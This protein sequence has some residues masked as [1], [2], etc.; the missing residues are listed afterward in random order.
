VRKASVVLVDRTRVEPGDRL[1]PIVGACLKAWALQDPEVA[2]AARIDVVQ[3]ADGESDE[4][5]VRRIVAGAPALVGFSCYVWNVAAVRGLAARVKR[6]L[7]DARIVLGGPEVGPIPERALAS[8]PAAD[9][10]CLGEGEETFRLLV[11]H[12]LLGAGAPAGVPGL[13]YR[14]ADGAVAS[15]G[16]APLIELGRA[17]SPHLDG[18]ARVPAG[19]DAMI[20]LSRGCAFECKFCDWPSL[21]L[22]RYVPMERVRRELAHLVAAGAGRVFVSDADILAHRRRGLEILR[23]FLDAAR[24]TECVL[25]FDSNPTFLG[26]EAAA[27]LASAPANFLVRFGLQ[28]VDEDALARSNRVLDLARVEDSLARLKDLSPGFPFMVSIIFGLPGEPLEGFARTLDW[29]FWMRPTAVIAA[30]ALV[31]PGAA[32]HR[33]AAALGLEFQRESPHQVLATSAMSADDLGVAREWA[34]AAELLFHVPGLLETALPPPS[35]TRRPGEQFES[36]RRW[37]A[38][39]RA[40]RFD[41]QFGMPVRAIDDEHVHGRVM[42]AWERLTADPLSLLALQRLSRGFRREESAAR[43]AR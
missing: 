29:V 14:G 17:A 25:T 43:V 4:S 22:V 41:L 3:S 15:T 34:F 40:K 32:Y 12:L 28:S 1:T 19:G 37:L 11:K 7:P 2:R 21:G 6:A 26:A 24:G 13:A 27:L 39:L 8:C 30:H 18:G 31:L 36:F 5:L 20:E 35:R 16:P 38:Y 9:Y 23:A 10:V 33:E 42:R